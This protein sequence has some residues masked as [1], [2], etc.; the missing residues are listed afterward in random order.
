MNNTDEYVAPSVERL[1]TVADLTQAHNLMNSDGG[2]M[3][4][5]ADSNP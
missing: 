5:D 3:A 2:G 1:G 4:N